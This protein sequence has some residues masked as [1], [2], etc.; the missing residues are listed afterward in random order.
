MT[1]DYV[2]QF[3]DEATAQ[4]DPVVGTYWIPPT[5]GPGPSSPGGWRGDSVIPNMQVWH[6]SQ[7][8]TNTIQGPNGP[9]D[10]IVHQYLPG[11]Y[12][13]ISKNQQDPALDNHKSME[14]TTQRE[15]AAV[16]ANFVGSISGRT[17]TVTQVTE[18]A[19]ASGMVLSGTGVRAGTTITSGS[20]TSW[21]VDLNQ[22]V[23]STNMNGQQTYIIATT[24]T[25][26]ELQDLFTQPMFAGALYP[27]LRNHGKW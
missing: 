24:Y 26:A 8:T 9:V 22:N 7:D 27:Y 10:I 12:I 16:F 20:G 17:L 19:I 14:L 4:A 15:G 3:T 21:Q 2:L 13:L 18:G 6:P 1:I 23:A 25:A 5:S 11:F